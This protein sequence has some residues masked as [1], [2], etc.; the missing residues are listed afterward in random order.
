MKRLLIKIVLLL[1]NCLLENGF[2]EVLL[3]VTYASVSFELAI[4]IWLLMNYPFQQW[5]ITIGLLVA[6]MYIH[7]IRQT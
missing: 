5:A 1:I 3:H 4:P 2:A 6:S 7:F